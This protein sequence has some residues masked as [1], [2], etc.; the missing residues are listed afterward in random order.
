MSTIQRCM[1]SSKPHTGLFDSSDHLKPPCV[2]R[3]KFEDT[4]KCALPLC[5]ACVIAN[6][7]ITTP[8]TESSTSSSFGILKQNDLSPGDCLSMDHFVVAKKGRS[9]SSQVPSFVGGSLFINHSFAKINI[10]HQDSLNGDKN[11]RSKR[12]MDR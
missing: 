10:F 7:E 11:L 8:S 1:S 4:N 6:Q 5:R 3:T 9:L 12:D 2:I